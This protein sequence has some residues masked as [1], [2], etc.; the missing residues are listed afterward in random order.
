[1]NELRNFELLSMH[2][3]IYK[4]FELIF[5]IITSGIVLLTKDF[6]RKWREYKQKYGPVFTIQLGKP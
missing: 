1:M 3:A 2:T 4:L 5:L 6:Q